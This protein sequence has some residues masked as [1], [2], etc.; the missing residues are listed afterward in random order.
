MV[1]CI[2]SNSIPQAK[3]HVYGAKN[4][5]EPTELLQQCVDLIGTLANL[6]GIQVEFGKM[7]FLGKVGVKIPCTENGNGVYNS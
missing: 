1:A 2:A 5:G 3:G 6:E 4:M 7:E